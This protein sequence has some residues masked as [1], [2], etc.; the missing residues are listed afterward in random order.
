MSHVCLQCALCY[1]KLAALSAACENTISCS[2][3]AAQHIQSQQTRPR[4]IYIVPAGATE[5]DKDMAWSCENMVHRLSGTLSVPPVQAAPTPCWR[6]RM[7]W[8]PWLASNSSPFPAVSHDVPVVDTEV[9]LARE[10]CQ[11]TRCRMRS[12]Y[13]TCVLVSTTALESLFCSSQHGRVSI[14]GHT[15][16]CSCQSPMHQHATALLSRPERLCTRRRDV[17]HQRFF[18]GAHH[19]PLSLNPA[20]YPHSGL[21]HSGD[22]IRSCDSSNLSSPGPTAAHSQSCA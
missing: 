12:R 2:Q 5:H 4:I 16:A 9:M 1:V 19:L 21:K 18:A 17:H 3:I 8:A 22:I 10:K 15:A 20:S 14:M 11:R 6:I 7:D 13:S